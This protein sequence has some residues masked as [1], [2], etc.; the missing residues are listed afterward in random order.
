M[1]LTN[2]NAGEAGPT[3]VDADSTVPTGVSLD[4]V[5]DEFD[6]PTL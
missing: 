3:V 2:G 5:R 6:P 4:Y 1:R